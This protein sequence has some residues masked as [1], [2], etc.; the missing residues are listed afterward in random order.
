MQ[1]TTRII[2]ACAVLAVC[3]TVNAQTAP[4]PGPGSGPM[5][6]PMGGGPMGGQM[7]WGPGV[8]PGWSLMTA[9]EQNAHREKMT[10]MKTYDECKAYLAEHHKD[11]QERAKAKGVDL[12]GGYGMAC[13]RM[14]AQGRLK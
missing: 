10:S 6:G 2:L 9:D 12:P 13:D 8:T 3:G 4:G 7:G 11:M 1:S 14:K 5:G